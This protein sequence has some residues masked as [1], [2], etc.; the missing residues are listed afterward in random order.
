MFIP[1]FLPSHIPRMQTVIPSLL[2]S[3][4]ARRTHTPS[5]QAHPEQT[6]FVGPPHVTRKLALFRHVEATT[7]A[8][9]RDYGVCG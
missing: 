7:A 1:T 4:P 5:A 8:T 6:S 9:S 3:P 2:P